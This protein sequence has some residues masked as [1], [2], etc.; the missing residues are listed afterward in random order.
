MLDI[1]IHEILTVNLAAYYLLTIISC[2]IVNMCVD[3]LSVFIGSSHE[4][5]I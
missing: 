1:D 3:I 2:K 5:N 4:I